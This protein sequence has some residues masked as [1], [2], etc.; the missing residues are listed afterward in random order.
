MTSSVEQRL[1]AMGLELPADW[2]PRGQFLPFRRDGAVVY[3][4]GQ[5][6]E[7][8]GEVTHT[9]P[10][11]DTPEGIEAAHKAAQTCA[12]NLLYRLRDACGGDLDRVDM[13]LRLGGFVNCAS[14]F[15]QSPAVINGATELFIALFGEGGWH[16]RTAVGVCGL[17]GNAS[18][19][20][21]AIVRLKS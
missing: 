7:W 3:L 6:C 4:S 20:V 14:G 5:I 11:S 8:D 16:A 10:V 2:A 13:I 17:P 12:L 19:E 9:G 21:D 1:T 18:V 15:G